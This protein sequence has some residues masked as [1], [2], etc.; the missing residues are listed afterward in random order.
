VEASE[1]LITASEIR[2]VRVEEAVEPPLLAAR[3]QQQRV[4]EMRVVYQ[5]VIFQVQRVEAVEAVL[6]P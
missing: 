6:L 4:W 1:E 5:L 2:V 3:L